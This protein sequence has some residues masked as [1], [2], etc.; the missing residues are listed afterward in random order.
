MI[1]WSL[2][3]LQNHIEQIATG[4][5]LIT[6]DDEPGMFILFRYPPKQVLRQADI[7]GEKVVVDARK[8]NFMTEEEMLEH[9]KLKG[10]WT[11]EHEKQIKGFREKIDKWQDKL[12]N[13]D[14]GEG[15]RKSI[16]TII[17]KLEEELWK[18]EIRRENALANT[19]ERVGRK[20]KYEYLVWLCSHDPFTQERMWPN[21]L[22]YCQALEEKDK[23]KMKLLNELIVFLSGHTTEEIRYVARH[24]LWRIN[25]IAA[26]KTNTPLFPGSV[27]EW[28]P[29]QLNLVW[30][31][32][33]Y[34][35]IYEMLPEDQPD[36]WVIED[37]DELD[38]YMGELHKER[39]KERAAKRDEKRYGPSTAMKMKEVL[40]TR[41][42]PDYERMEYDKPPTA[43]QG[44]TKTLTDDS[45]MKG[46]SRKRAQAVTKS[47]RYVPEESE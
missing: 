20:E 40:V 5:K 38:K 13:P 39:S 19:V 44:D 36:D 28:T 33:Y 8:D 7:Q 17:S 37:D 46:A 34:Q 27:V 23:V 26:Q 45:Q 18:I 42:H 14:I 22:T 47:K 12:R 16:S 43:Q 6:L 10:I 21:Y 30:W 2:E 24:N 29:D 32:S 9:L 4:E 25:Y 31:S 15:S 35:S 1:D 3:E 41:A 11:D